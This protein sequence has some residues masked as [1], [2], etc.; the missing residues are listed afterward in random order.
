MERR[1]EEG[2]GSIPGHAPCHV[3]AVERGIYES[4]G[5]LVGLGSGKMCTQ[6]AKEEEKWKG[7]MREAGTEAPRKRVM[8]VLGVPGKQSERDGGPG[9]SRSSL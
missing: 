3:L 6:E 9:S 4:G 7:Q 1:M 5:I 8:P 2:G